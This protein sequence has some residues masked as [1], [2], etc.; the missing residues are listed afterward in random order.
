MFMGA[1]KLVTVKKLIPL[2]KG[3]DKAKSIELIELNEVGNLIVSQIGLYAVGDKAI[4][5]EPGYCIPNTPIFKGFYPAANEKGKSKLGKCGRI[6]AVK[7]NLH[8]GDNKPIYS[9]GI[10]LS[11]DEVHKLEGSILGFSINDEGSW[12]SALGVTKCEHPENFLET[13][14]KIPMRRYD[15]PYP[16]DMYK[17]EE[18]NIN[19]LW[20][21]LKYPIELIGMPRFGGTPVTIYNKVVDGERVSGVTSKNYAKPVFVN[22][23][24]GRRKLS[25]WES[26]CKAFGCDVDLDI[27]EEVPNND[28]LVVVAKPYLEKLE[29]ELAGSLSSEALRGEI[30]GKGFIKSSSFD[31]AKPW[32]K[33]H[34]SDYFDK[35]GIAVKHAHE[36][37]D[38]TMFDMEG[39]DVQDVV[40]KRV[41]RSKKQ[42]IDRCQE[43]FDKYEKKGT[44]LKS[45]VLRT[46]DSKW[47]AE[48]I[49][50]KHD[51]KRQ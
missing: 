4:F 17:D 26:L 48:V 43:V 1:V 16:L 19:N 44:L 51:A 3:E 34:G 28:P 30:L 5:I 10:L 11:Y 46:P 7:F 22:K 40:I 12:E 2:Y 9:Y 29:D 23:I 47:S 18:V 33:F 37:F 24:V 36:A 14:G 20:K 38:I 27:I 39:F 6:K 25:W 42:I 32:I 31:N 35:D 41:F 13:R 21:D 8:T 45:V 49:N 50:L 15:K